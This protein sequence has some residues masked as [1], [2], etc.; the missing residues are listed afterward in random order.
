MKRQDADAPPEREQTPRQRLAEALEHGPATVREL[1]QMASLTERQ[2]LDNLEHVRKS[3]ERQGRRLAMEP[4]SCQDCGFEFAKRDKPS[5]PGRCP[6]CK[7]RRT[8]Q[9]RFSIR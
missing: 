1:S 6:V 8:S 5:R 2:V 4:A 9:P 7:S 3:V